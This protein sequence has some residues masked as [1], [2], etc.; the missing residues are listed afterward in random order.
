M[1][2]ADCKERMDKFITALAGCGNVSIS[3]KAAGICRATANAWKKQFS[4][5]ADRWADAMEDA[6]DLLEAEAWRR[7]LEEGSDGL[8][9]FLLMAHKS[10]IYG[11]KLKVEHQGNIEITW[12]DD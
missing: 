9:K 11:E 12:D 1:K 3:C 6:V 4:T 7:S 5:F 8:L 2:L 10:E